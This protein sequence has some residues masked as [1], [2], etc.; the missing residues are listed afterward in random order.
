MKAFTDM[1]RA[2]VVNGGSPAVSLAYARRRRSTI[3]QTKEKD[4]KKKYRVRHHP[5]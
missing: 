3:A 5:S 2:V 1:V 4:A